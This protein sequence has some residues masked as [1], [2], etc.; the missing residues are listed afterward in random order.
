MF[1][2]VGI[3]LSKLFCLLVTYW[4]VASLLIFWV[5]S[6]ILVFVLNFGWFMFALL[7]VVCAGTV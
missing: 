3:G 4:L 1:I 5:F 2:G 7:R 6:V